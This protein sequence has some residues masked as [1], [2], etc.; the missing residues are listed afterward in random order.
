MY[1][2]TTL[3]ADE[4]FEGGKND[5][6]AAL[7]SSSKPLFPLDEMR[8]NPSDQAYAMGWNAVWAGAENNARWKA[9][10]FSQHGTQ[11]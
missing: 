9:V 1:A 4:A 3:P 5:A 2:N 10:D 6:L 7:Q 8:D 11:G